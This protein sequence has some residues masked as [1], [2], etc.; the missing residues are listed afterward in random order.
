MT[1]D[2]D[3]PYSPFMASAIKRSRG[4]A[5][6]AVV[7]LLAVLHM[8][9]LSLLH[10]LGGDDVCDWAPGQHDAN[11]RTIRAATP[12][13]L[14]P[15]C[16]IC[17]WWQSAGRFKSSTPPP[18]LV[19]IVDFGLVAK[20]LVIAPELSVATVRSARAPPAS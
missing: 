2:P 3:H 4:T 13:P 10:G 1:S 16:A 5:L 7:A 19:P 15:H 20:P 14:S 9:A 18:T 6:A 17:H 11:A 12:V 8:P